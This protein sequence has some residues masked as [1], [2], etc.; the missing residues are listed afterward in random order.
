[1]PHIEADERIRAKKFESCCSSFSPVQKFTNF[2]ERGVGVTLR[3]KDE[4]ADD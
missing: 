2:L 1:V 3:S 4:A